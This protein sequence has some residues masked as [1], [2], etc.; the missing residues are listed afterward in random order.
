MIKA[1]SILWLAVFVPIVLLMIPTSIN[2]I[3]RIS[4]SF[5]ED[6][7]KQ[8]YSANFEILS[9]ELLALPKNQWQSTIANYSAHFGYPL[10]L[11]PIEEY[12]SESSLYDAL[13]RREIKFLY[14][15]PM[16]L[17]QRV[18]DSDQVI[19]LALNESTELAVLNQAKGVLYLAVKDLRRYPESEW[20]Q[21]IATQNSNIPF[22]ISLKTDSELSPEATKALIGKS[23]ETISYTNHLGEINLLAPVAPN[24]WLHV[25]DNISTATEM[26]LISAIVIFFFLFI[27]IAMVMWVYPLWR[28]LKRLVRTS[29]EFGQGVLSKRATASKMSVIS[30]LSDSFNKMADNIQ[31]L[32]AG[33]RE[34]TNAI[35]HDLRTPLYRLRF[36]LEMAEETDTPEELKEKYRQTIHSSIDDLDHLINQSLLLSRYNRVADMNQFS[37][38]CF[39]DSLITEVEYF[40]LENPV[41][42]IRFYCSPDLKEQQ[43]FIDNKGLMR[44]VKN[45][46]TNAS[47]FAKETITISFEVE[48][49][50][51][52]ILVED[53]GVGIPIEQAERIFEPFAQLENQERRSDKGHGLGLAIVKQIMIWHKGTVSIGTSSPQGAVFELSWP[54]HPLLSETKLDNVTNLDTNRP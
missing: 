51:Y 22:Q 44:A 16:A 20:A 15:D 12:K 4:E 35:A 6:F 33:Q 18:G 23:Q 48:G 46:L 2:P 38:C 29:N 45:L 40:K 25:Q 39:S 41:L 50:Q 1:F 24:V 37:N 53:D 43:L 10:K 7:Y 26:K 27:S 30:Q 52:R 32:I 47:R 5:S 28:D 21:I 11:Q 17:L 19:Y 14:G 54:I 34:L 8:T 36:A 31:K 42:D 9:E 13:Q 49:G 3:Q